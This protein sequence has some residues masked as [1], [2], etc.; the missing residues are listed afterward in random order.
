MKTTYVQQW[1]LTLQKQL[2]KSWLFKA[3]YLGN[4]TAHLWTDQELNPAVYI[5]GNCVAG[6]YGLTK[7]GPCSTTANT[8]ARRLFTQLNPSQGPFYGTV[9][10]LDDGGTASY[11]AMMLSA[12]HRLSNHFSMLANYTLAHCIADPQTTELSAPIYTNPANRRSDRGNCTAVDVRHN[13]NLSAVLQSPRYLKPARPM[14]RRRLA[15]RAH[16]QRAYGALLYGD[17]RRGQC[18]DRGEHCCATT[19]PGGRPKP[20]RMHDRRRHGACGNAKLLVQSEGVRRPGP[21]NARQSGYQQYGKPGIFDVDVALSRRFHISERQYIEIRAEAFNIQNRANFLSPSTV[22]LAGGTS[23][24]AL[25]SS[26][27]GRIQ[28]D[29]G[30]RIM[31]FALKYSF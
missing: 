2:G 23:G 1:N 3:S 25:N 4:E 10:N 19:Q 13:F 9:E 31:Q 29:V 8:Q 22:S 5:P 27:F 18:V 12:E 6:Q 15:A 28:A 11:N 16:R 21:R 17:D 20:G 30:P 26:T 24:A 14:D 7:A